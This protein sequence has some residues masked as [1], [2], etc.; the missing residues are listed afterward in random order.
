M[1]ITFLIKGCAW[2]QCGTWKFH[3]EADACDL[4]EKLTPDVQADLAFI[5]SS[6]LITRGIKKKKNLSATSL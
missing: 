5:P 2:V 6:Q 1:Q 3:P 4:V